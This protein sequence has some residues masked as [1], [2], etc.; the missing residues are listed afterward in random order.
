MKRLQITLLIVATAAV[1]CAATVVWTGPPA[2]HMLTA[3]C[4]AASRWC[5]GTVSV[6]EQV[7]GSEGGPQALEGFTR[8]DTRG[9]VRLALGTIGNVEQAG[10]GEIIEARSV[11]AGGV[12]TGTGPIR[13]WVGVF[14]DRPKVKGTNT[15]APNIADFRAI[16]F[17]NGLYLT[18]DVDQDGRPVLKL[19]TDD[20]RQAPCMIFKP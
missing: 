15:L 18:T 8:V 6:I 5:L 19:C 16:Q 7:T 4:G 13:R 12:V 17:N 1:S 3:T 10:S 20:P 2:G 14:I 11:Q 9:S